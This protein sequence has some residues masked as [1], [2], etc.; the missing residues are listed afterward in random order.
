[1]NT[2]NETIISEHYTE[3]TKE[4]KNK[5]SIKEIKRYAHLARTRGQYIE[6]EINGND[7]YYFDG[8]LHFFAGN[9]AVTIYKAEGEYQRQF[10]RKHTGPKPRSRRTE[11]DDSYDYEDCDYLD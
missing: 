1:M 6:T 10:A 4:R 8:F 5:K 11:I 9:V 7:I 2:L 3:R